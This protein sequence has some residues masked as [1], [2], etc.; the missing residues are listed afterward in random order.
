MLESI[1]QA[2]TAFW[3]AMAIAVGGGWFA[4][5]T[6]DG[7][8]EKVFCAERPFRIRR[9]FPLRGAPDLVEQK[10][11]GKLVIVDYKTR[12]NESVMDSDLIQLSLYALLVS[13]STGRVVD[14]IGFVEFLSGRRVAVRLLSEDVLVGI[15]QRRRL[16]MSGDEKPL[17][18]CKKG[19]CQ[20]CQ[21]MGKECFPSDG[22]RARPLTQM[23]NSSKDR[24][25]SSS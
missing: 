15:W 23:R 21:Y 1:A 11:G 22:Q 25:S 5:V 6:W 3:I 16:I 10:R 18:A 20:S 12:G 2:G 17:F 13:G 19:L 8:R 14:D 4:Y 24:R 9:P 7:R